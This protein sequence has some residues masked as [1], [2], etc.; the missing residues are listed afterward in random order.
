[1][2]SE[3]PK[4]LHLGNIVKEQVDRKG[5]RTVWLAEQ[6]HCHRNN[7]YKIYEK[8]WIDTELLLKLSFILNCDFFAI[9][10]EYYKRE[11]KSSH[12]FTT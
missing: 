2:K 4:E 6:L 3:I 12:K 8:Q 10:S 7:I 1:M 9:I 5:Y 11:R